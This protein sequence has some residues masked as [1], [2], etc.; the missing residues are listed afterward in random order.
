MQ[1]TGLVESHVEAVPANQPLFKPLESYSA[2]P[3]NFQT[4]SS[5]T[6]TQV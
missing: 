1:C 3:V 5:Q 2:A 4:P 6:S